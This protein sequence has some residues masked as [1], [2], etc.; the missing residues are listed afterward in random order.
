MKILAFALQVLA[1]DSEGYFIPLGRWKTVL[2][3]SHVPDEEP[4]VLEQGKPVTMGDINDFLARAQGID[5][6]H[7]ALPEVMQVPSLVTPPVEI[8]AEEAI[9]VLR[10]QVR[11]EYISGIDSPSSLYH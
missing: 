6:T 7:K 5:E 9:A 1:E 3:N 11:E 10:G 4:L 8:T 2:G